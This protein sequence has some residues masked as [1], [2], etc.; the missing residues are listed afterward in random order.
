MTSIDPVNEAQL[1]ALIAA[2][3]SAGQRIVA[4]FGPA[5]Q[6]AYNMIGAGAFHL[7]SA[8]FG[9]RLY[10]PEHATKDLDEQWQTLSTAALN[11]VPAAVVPRST[12]VQPRS[13]PAI[14]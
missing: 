10:P 3:N 5:M 11:L 6:I 2:S 12:C 7:D 9:L 8:R 1:S 14:T 4:S 13:S